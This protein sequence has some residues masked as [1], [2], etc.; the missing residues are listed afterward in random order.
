[1]QTEVPAAK[2]AGPVWGCVFFWDGAGGR[3]DRARCVSGAVQD[4]LGSHADGDFR[5]SLRLDRQA[6]GRMDAC[7][8]FLRDAVFHQEGV[9]RS[10]LLPAPDAADIGRLRAHRLKQHRAIGLMAGRHDNDIVLRADADLFADVLIVAQNDAVRIRINLLLCKIRAVVEYG[11]AELHTRQYRHERPSDVSAAEDIDPA[12]TAHRLDV[13]R[14][15]AFTVDGVG[16]QHW[17]QSLHGNAV[18]KTKPM[19]LVIEPH[20]NRRICVHLHEQPAIFAAPEHFQQRIRERQLLRLQNLIIDRHIAA[21]DHPDVADL[22]L[23]EP[24]CAQQIFS[25]AQQLQR[26]F[27]GDPLDRAAADGAGGM[28]VRKD[29]HPGT[30]TSRCGP[31]RGQNGTQHRIFA[32]RQ[33]RADLF[34]QLFNK[35]CSLLFY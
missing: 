35:P 21:A 8:R 29:G 2:A 28:S 16:E 23:R 18:Q 17:P 15:L 31:G 6:D 22:I 24:E 19:P 12:R 9:R 10:D 26:L 3:A 32:A 20:P 4:Q 33:C 1:M 13:P 7:E 5:R 30:G 27:G 11:H 14:L 34:K 25:G